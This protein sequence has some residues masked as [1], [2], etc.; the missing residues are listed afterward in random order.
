MYRLLFV[1]EE[2][3]GNFQSVVFY[4]R[5]L[6]IKTEGEDYIHEVWQVD[7]VGDCFCDGSSLCYYRCRR[8][9]DDD[10]Y[11]CYIDYSCWWIED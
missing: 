9:F 2:G 5:P 4:R 6:I 8:F 7:E 10:N 11:V 1:K 3:T